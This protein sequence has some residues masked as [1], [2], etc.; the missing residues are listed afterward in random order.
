MKML[1]QSLH[2][3]LHTSQCFTLP[4]AWN[5]SQADCILLFLQTFCLNTR[6]LSNCRIG[7][8]I[9]LRDLFCTKIALQLSR[10][11][12]SFNVVKPIPVMVLFVFMVLHIAGNW[13][14]CFSLIL[15]KAFNK[16]AA[17][18]HVVMRLK[19]CNICVCTLLG[20]CFSLLI[21][22]LYWD[23]NLFAWSAFY[24]CTWLYTSWHLI[25]CS[26]LKW[27]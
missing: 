13:K 16:T 10:E 3:R 8:T 27:I 24:I 1:W 20:L 15:Y 5:T 7:M 12:K 2:Y 22:V 9:P 23:R 25:I 19:N 18:W 17:L 11:E 21:I 26:V 4:A 6:I 14:H